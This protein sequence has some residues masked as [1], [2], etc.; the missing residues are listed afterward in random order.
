MRPRLS[1]RP[2]RQRLCIVAEVCHGASDTDT[3]R[4]APDGHDLEPLDPLVEAAG[5]PSFGHPLS[6]SARLAPPL[7]MTP[8]RSPSNSRRGRSSWSGGVHNRASAQRLSRA[9]RRVL[10]R[11]NGSPM[12]V[13]TNSCSR[14]ACMCV[15]TRAV[16]TARFNDCST[17]VG[18][19]DRPAAAAC[20]RGVCRESKG[21]VGGAECCR[22][23]HDARIHGHPYC[24]ATTGLCASAQH[25]AQGHRQHLRAL[26]ECR[27]CDVHSAHPM[28][29]CMQPVCM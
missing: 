27:Y 5:S 26:L 23:I 14:G 8:K 15:V 6:R 21:C 17:L 12:M 24:L 4:R 19:D 20:G 3:W 1:F 7:P 22:G 16:M 11:Q 13:S 28:S 10:A 25:L 9:R 2:R 18:G 29:T